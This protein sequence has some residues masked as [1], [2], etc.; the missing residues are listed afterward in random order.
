MGTCTWTGNRQCTYKF[1]NPNKEGWWIKN[2]MK[3]IRSC[4]RY[5]KPATKRSFLKLVLKDSKYGRAHM[6]TFFA[7]AKDA[8][9]VELHEQWN[10]KYRDCRYTRGD[11]WNAYLDGRLERYNYK[12]H[13]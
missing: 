12:K 8:G 7:A 6:N 4:E 1:E 5:D 3:Y 11:N 2:F 10:G 9:I 13:G